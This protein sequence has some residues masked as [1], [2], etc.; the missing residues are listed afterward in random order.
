MTTTFAAPANSPAP[1]LA[2]LLGVI[3]AGAAWAPRSRQTAI[4][5]SEIGQPCKRRMAL[6][7]LG[8]PDHN[9]QADRWA[10][11][12]GTATHAWLEQTFTEDNLRRAREGG[13]HRWALEE[14]LQIREGLSGS[15][16][17]YD[18]ATD[19]VVDW[20]VVGASSLKK[21]KAGGPGPQYRTQAHTYGLGWLNRGRP[22]KKVAIVFLPRAGWLADT[23]YWEEEFQPEVARGALTAMDELIEGMNIAEGLGVLDEML[24]LLPRDGSACVFCPYKTNNPNVGPADGCPGAPKKGS[25]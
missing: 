11:T 16:D 5:P 1:L 24:E 15:C 6:K 7:I 18:L 10:S 8:A 9:P 14:R 3:H 23:Y 20:K 4:G 22:V 12:I 25:L 13:E 2:D 17:L 21:Y 19:T